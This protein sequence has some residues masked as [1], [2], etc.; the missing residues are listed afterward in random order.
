MA[1]FQWNTDMYVGFFLIICTMA[2]LLFPPKFG[3]GYYG[4]AT[5]WTKKNETIW[6]FGHKLFAVSILLIGLICLTIGSFKLHE[7]IPSFAMVFIIFVLWN[8][9]KFFIHM[10]LANKFPN[11]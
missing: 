2:I 7:A 6:A 3:N 10:I 9:S 4:I 1:N 11:A 5:K 8:I